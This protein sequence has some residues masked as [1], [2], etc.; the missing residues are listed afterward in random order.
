MSF[1]AQI[2]IAVLI[3]ISGTMTGIKYHAGQDARA[4]LAARELRDSDARQQRMVGERKSADHAKAIGRIATQLGNA[5]EKLAQ[6]PGRDCLAPSDVL[7]L[8]DIGSAD[9]RSTAGQ[10]PNP[11]PAASS[12]A[13]LRYSTDRDLAG[14]I[15]VCRARYAEVT[16]QLNQI[17]DI[18]DSRHPPGKE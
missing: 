11:A 2:V 3:F 12:G 9:V 7:V 10:S 13:G 16:D 17:L 15:A 6:L 18:E 1:T 14:A 5:R 8:N 4:E